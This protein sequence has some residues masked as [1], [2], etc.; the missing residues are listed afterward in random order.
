MAIDK[1]LLVERL[2]QRIDLD[3]IFLFSYSFLGKEQQHLILVMKPEDGV[4]P[5]V[6]KPVIE[7]CLIDTKELSF[8]LIPFGEWRNK[9]RHGGLYYAYAYR[10][11]NLEPIALTCNP[12]QLLEISILENNLLI[13]AK[14]D[15]GNLVLPIL[16]THMSTVLTLTDDE[17]SQI[18]RDFNREMAFRE[19]VK[20]QHD[21]LIDNEELHSWYL[22]LPH[23]A[24]TNWIEIFSHQCKN[25]GID[26]YKEK[27]KPGSKHYPHQLRWK[28]ME[29]IQKEDFLY[30]KIVFKVGEREIELLDFKNYLF[31]NKNCFTLE[32]GNCF[33]L[34]NNAKNLF[35][36]LFIQ[37][38]I[39]NCYL[40][41]T[42]AQTLAFHNALMEIDPKIIDS[43]VQER[44]ERLAKLEEIPQLPVPSTVQ[45]TLR[46]YQIA[47]FSWMVFLNEFQWGGLLA[48]DMGLGKTLQV[49]TLLEHFYQAH[50]LASASLVVVP[51]SLL[52][53]WQNEYQKFAP[54]R[55]IVV[56]YGSN[57]QNSTD[58]GADV[59]VL[60]TYG[61]LLS[62][63]DFFAKKSF[64]YLIMDESQHVKNRNSKRFESLSR[65]NAQYRIAMTG[66]PIENG[67]QDIY[68]QMN[69]VNP[70]FFGNY[71]T[72]NKL[73]KSGTDAD[74]MNETLSNLQ[75][76]I[77]PFIL[78]RTKK[79]VALDLPEKTETILYMDMTPAQRQVYQKYRKT[80]QGEVQR[81]LE[82]KD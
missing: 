17:I 26:V 70:D 80:F 36:P 48:D 6:M 40:V 46:P 9:V 73:Y 55:E 29:I 7:L 49:I 76:V 1:R 44:R 32:D 47:G 25:T 59:I 5:K 77:Q 52:F 75:K 54:N 38:R 67:I 31:E 22:P 8:E 58:F 50:P 28:L 81:S 18:Q 65:V 41:L 19:F 24:Y 42:S 23:I 45:A 82:S 39:E 79:Q 10:Q 60:T 66:T 34:S 71:R 68:S 15:Y 78:R 57:R 20:S 4:S 2:I 13:K 11:E 74:T 12:T 27:I 64:S 56:Y 16:Q 72:F 21:A 37:G 51:N 53:N 62:D 3:R 69:L 35:S 61:T 14:I 63:S 33:F 30:L 43:S